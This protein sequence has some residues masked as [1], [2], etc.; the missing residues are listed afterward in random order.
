MQICR[1]IEYSV[2][3]TI[4]TLNACLAVCGPGKMLP[5]KAKLLLLSN[6]GG[7]QLPFNLFVMAIAYPIQ[8]YSMTSVGKWELLQHCKRL[9]PNHYQK[10][11]L[12]EQSWNKLSA[13]FKR[14]VLSPDIPVGLDGLKKSPQ[15]LP[16]LSVQLLENEV[17]LCPKTNRRV[18]GAVYQYLKT[19]LDRRQ[20]IIFYSWSE[21]WD[22]LKDQKKAIYLNDTLNL[23]YYEYRI[24]Q[25][26][27]KVQE[28]VKAE[29]SAGDSFYKIAENYFKPIR[30]DAMMEALVS[31]ASFD[32]HSEVDVGMKIQWKEIQEKWCK[33]FYTYKTTPEFKSDLHSF[34]GAIKKMVQVHP[35]PIFNYMEAFF[36][37][38]LIHFEHECMQSEITEMQNFLFK[39]DKF[40]NRIKE[41]IGG[42][43]DAIAPID[44]IFQTIYRENIDKISFDLI[45]FQSLQ[46]AE[47]QYERD[48]QSLCQVYQQH[49]EIQTDLY[50]S[51]YKK[52][53]ELCKK[54]NDTEKLKIFVLKNEFNQFL[55]NTLNPLVSIPFDISFHLESIDEGKELSKKGIKSGSRKNKK[56]KKKDIS[57]NRQ[58]RSSSNVSDQTEQEQLD[59]SPTIASAIE[60]CEVEDDELNDEKNKVELP[61]VKPLFEKIID[62]FESSI[63][64]YAFRVIRWFEAYSD[65]YLDASNFPEYQH[66]AP[67]YQKQMIQYHAFSQS[68]DHF[69]EKLA[70]K[71]FWPNKYSNEPN[72]RYILP[73]EITIQGKSERGAFVYSFDQKG[74]LYHRFFSPKSTD[75]LVKKVTS[76]AFQEVD[77]PELSEVDEV[78]KWKEGKLAISYSQGDELISKHK[79]LGIISIDNILT[80]VRMTL[81]PVHSTL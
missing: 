10:G 19:P 54:L 24:V 42:G 25:V 60:E 74:V 51:I 15:L 68:V 69:V 13:I 5:F 43:E 33:L 66:Y 78:I 17:V 35:S 14:I 75:E 64:T 56:G 49:Q 65:G 26:L 18:A 21:N 50:I 34:Y 36:F 31:I 7:D 38:E 2:P 59:S 67:A 29:K 77:F 80:G 28:I 53:S 47:P 1:F 30:L 3:P 32:D 39:K 71:A 48:I 46:S 11:S 27:S 37:K 6:E 81:F 70:L 23:L 44:S 58:A 63:F 76:Q 40:V 12:E 61:C 8:S 45:N 16:S 9:Y 4:E 55:P 79:Y 22:T 62:P 57:Q 41:M 72:L 52:L 73:G 20:E